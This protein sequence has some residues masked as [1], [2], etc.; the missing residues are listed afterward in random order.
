VP[1]PILNFYARTFSFFSALSTPNLHSILVSHYH[2]N[3]FLL[4]SRFVEIDRFDNIIFHSEATK[5]K[6]HTKDVEQE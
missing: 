4:P 5:D 6:W 2:S 1:Q 3:I